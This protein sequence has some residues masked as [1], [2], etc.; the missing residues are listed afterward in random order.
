M[1]SKDDIIYS[2]TTRQAVEDGVLVEI[3]KTASS[4][5]GIKF[6]MYFTSAVWHR[7]VEFSKEFSGVQDLNARLADILFMFAWQ[8]KKCSGNTLQFVFCSLIPHNAEWQSYE[9]KS[10]IGFQHRD[11]TLKAVIG[12]S[13]IDNPAPSIFI[14]L[15]WED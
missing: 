14:M 10:S 7:Y 12:P 4:N 2:Y 9:K 11:V 5:K 1:F 6:P 15:P 13:D 8:A 3:D